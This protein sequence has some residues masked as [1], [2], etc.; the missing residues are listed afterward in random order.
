MIDPPRPRL[1]RLPL[2][3]R[4]HLAGAVI[5][6]VGLAVAAWIR[7]TTPEMPDAVVS[8]Q[9]LKVQ[10][11][12]LEIIGGK[13]AVEAARLTRWFDGLWVGRDLATTRSEERRVG[14]ECRRLC[15]SRWSPYH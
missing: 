12:Q 6:V 1:A 14:K 13:F 2:S 5:A 7:L 3:L 15:R 9:R 8:L 10:E 11:R 4:F